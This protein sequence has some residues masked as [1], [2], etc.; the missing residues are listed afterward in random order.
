MKALICTLLLAATSN[1]PGWLKDTQICNGW[2]KAWDEASMAQ[3]KGM[4]LMIG[5]QADKKIIEKAHKQGNKVLVYVTFYQMPPGQVYQQADLAEHAD[6][7]V[8]HPDGDLDIRGHRKHRMEDGLSELADVS[9]VCPQAH[10]VHHGS[11]RGR[12][13]H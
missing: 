6:W 13:F 8:I 7:N 12:S 9:G 4:P 10:Q 11:G 1:T 2:Y 3:M 5:I